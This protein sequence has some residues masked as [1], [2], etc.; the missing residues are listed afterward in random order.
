MKPISFFR[1]SLLLL[2]LCYAGS[3]R[4][5]P[6][7]ASDAAH[8]ARPHSSGHDTEKLL[9]TALSLVSVGVVLRR[10]SP[11]IAEFLDVPVS[12]RA[13]LKSLGTGEGETWTP[14]RRTWVLGDFGLRPP[15]DGV[16]EPFSDGDESPGSHPSSPSR[17]ESISGESGEMVETAGEDSPLPGSLSPDGFTQAFFAHVPE[18]FAA[19]RS[20]ILELGQA[21]N[22]DTQEVLINLYLC[23]HSLTC[24]AEWARLPTVLKVTSALEGLLKKLMESPAQLT[25]STH[26]TVAHAVE[27]LA[28]LCGPGLDPNLASQ[29]PIRMLVADDDM[30][31]RRAMRCA[32][33]MAFDK[34]DSADHGEAALA[35]AQQNRYE[36]IFLDVQM[37]GMDGFELCSKIHETP[38]NSTTP[39]VFV[40]SQ[41]DLQTRAQGALS[42][43]SDFITKPFLLSEI[44]VKALTLALRARLQKLQQAQADAMLV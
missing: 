1:L 16:G 32:L 22:D 10:F 19:L 11:R 8:S 21:A 23:V 34:P 26:R 4:A 40:T 24:K 42:G 29:P 44:T 30:L 36:V 6:S 37:P 41:S 39:V 2:G 15:R 25:P 20:L 3:C 28:A 17:R 38:V 5:A 13:L 33:Q 18:H 14:Q 31:S 35:L 7:P 9:W 12:P 43:G 27:L